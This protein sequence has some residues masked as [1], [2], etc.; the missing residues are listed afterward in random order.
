MN[1]ESWKDVCVISGQHEYSDAKSLIDNVV[2]HVL[3]T[4]SQTQKAVVIEA[5][6]LTTMGIA[7]LC[8][9][10]C[11]IVIQGV[12]RVGGFCDTSAIRE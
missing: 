11:R 5:E 10:G 6:H 12:L 4:N 8:Q 3:A 2:I 7:V 9:V 1:Y